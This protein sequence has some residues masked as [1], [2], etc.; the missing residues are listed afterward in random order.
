M[1]RYVVIG[2]LVAIVAGAAFAFTRF[3]E[4]VSECKYVG[5]QGEAQRNEYLAAQRYLERTGHK[6]HHLRGLDA[7]KRMPA[8]AS[9]VW[10]RASSEGEREQV[11]AWVKRGG[12][13]VLDGPYGHEALLEEI[14]V[15]V[16]DPARPQSE[17]DETQAED[18]SAETDAADETNEANETT[19][20]EEP[21]GAQSETAQA[22]QRSAKGRTDEGADC[23]SRRGPLDPYTLVPPIRVSA[24]RE[25]FDVMVLTT[26]RLHTQQEGPEPLRAAASEEGAVM[27]EHALERGRVSVLVNGLALRNASIG[28]HD[29]AAWLSYLVAAPRAALAQGEPGGAAAHQVWFA[30]VPLT[31]SLWDWLRAHAWPVLI[32][33]GIAIALGLW[34][35]LARFGPLLPDA[36]PGRLSFRDHL[37]ACGRF[38]WRHAAAG[39]L[40]DSVEQEANR[41]QGLHGVDQAITAPRRLLGRAAE[42]PAFVNV[43]KTLQRKLSARKVGPTPPKDS[44]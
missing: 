27:L 18:E 7:F 44:E 13:L 11:L 28:E 14:G 32:A 2:V 43:V 21:A 41:A 25:Q 31:A 17:Q 5:Y 24:E 30:D 15:E 34:R 12:H 10:S 3:F 35:A 39:H 42:A 16:F 9:L 4:Q 40:L 37:V 19:E 26:E 1:N 6:V 33:G 36:P 20:I 8:G 23:S 38:H 22:A 29:H